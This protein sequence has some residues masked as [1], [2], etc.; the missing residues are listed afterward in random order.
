MEGFPK[1]SFIQRLKAYNNK[2]EINFKF[3]YGYHAS[4]R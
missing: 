3:E 2:V 1:T 4:D